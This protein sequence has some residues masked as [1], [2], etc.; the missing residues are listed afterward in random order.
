MPVFSDCWRLLTTAGGFWQLSEIVDKF[1]FFL[2]ISWGFWHLLEVF[3]ITERIWQLLYVPFWLF[4]NVSD[5][6]KRFPTNNRWFQTLSE[7]SKNYHTFSTI[8]VGHNFHLVV[9]LVRMFL[10]NCRIKTF[11]KH[12]QAICHLLTYCNLLI[13]HRN[14]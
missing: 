7:V 12:F 6:L 4:F 9:H 13:F 2:V 5:T 1:R 8:S 14:R 3:D 11:S 10:I